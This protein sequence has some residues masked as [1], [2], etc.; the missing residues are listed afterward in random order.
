MRKFTEQD[1]ELIRLELCSRLPYGLRGRVVATC[2]D[3]NHVD[4][5]GFYGE[6]D[7]DVDVE[8]DKIDIVNYEIH[9]TA[10][11][12]GND[13]LCDYIEESQTMGEPWTIFDF[14]PYLRP[15]SSMTEEERIEMREF[16]DSKPKLIYDIGVAGQ[17]HSPNVIDFL[18]SHHFD[19]RGL[20]EKGLALEAPEGIYDDNE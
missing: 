6:K 15:M 12:N 4:M 19:Y 16:C 10:L 9:V 13:D 1:E 7:F 11:G 3:T 20:I 17:I 18:N 5:D 8:L 2:V 14:K